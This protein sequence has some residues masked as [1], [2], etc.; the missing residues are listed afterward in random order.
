MNIPAYKVTK[1]YYTF[2]ALINQQSNA[3]FEI[4]LLQKQNLGDAWTNNL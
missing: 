1:L 3:V 4:K 2:L